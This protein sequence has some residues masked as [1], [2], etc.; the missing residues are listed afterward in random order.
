MAAPGGGGAV[1]LQLVCCV[2]PASGCSEGARRRAVQPPMRHPI[3]LR[4]GDGGSG[5]LDAPGVPVQW[6]V[7]AGAPEVSVGLYG[8]VMGEPDRCLLSDVVT[9]RCGESST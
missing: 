1:R 3:D 4:R 8:V 5:R 2:D 6:Q 7:L 9:T